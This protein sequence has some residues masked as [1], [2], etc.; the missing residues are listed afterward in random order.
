[1]TG[2]FSFISPNFLSYKI[3]FPKILLLLPIFLYFIFIGRFL[4]NFPLGDDWDAILNFINEWIATGPY[5]E[6]IN[7]LFS[8]HNEHRLVFGRFVT[9][10]YWKVFGVVNFKAIALFG[11][12]AWIGLFIFLVNIAKRADFSVFE[13][14]AISYLFFN[15][16]NW[17]LILWSMAAVQQYSQLLFSIISI[18]FCIKN[19]ILLSLAMYA[20]AVFTGAGGCWLDQSC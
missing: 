1:M 6:K 7:L 5:S 14:C 11:N 15:F 3:L 13:T 20:L 18:W 9:L 17:D 4:V 19:K 2:F 12:I 10:I 16:A 8:Q